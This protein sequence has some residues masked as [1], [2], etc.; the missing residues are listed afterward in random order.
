[1]ARTRPCST[2]TKPFN[3]P[4]RKAPQTNPPLRTVCFLH[5]VITLYH[6]SRRDGNRKICSLFPTNLRTT[7]AEIQDIIVLQRQ[8]FIF[9]PPINGGG[10]E[11]IMKRKKKGRKILAGV[12]AAAIVAGL[13]PSFSLHAQAEEKPSGDGS[14][15]NPYRITSQAE[16]EWISQDPD[17]SYVLSNDIALSGEWKPIDFQGV[18]DGQGHTISGL[19]VPRGNQY[20]EAGLFG[21]V[22]GEIRNLTVQIADGGE[23]A[24]ASAG[25]V[26]GYLHGDSNSVHGDYG[27]EPARMV[28]C[29][30]EGGA[31]LGASSGAYE[32]GGL[33]GYMSDAILE[34]CSSSCTVLDMDGNALITGM[35]LEQDSYILANIYDTESENPNGVTI[36]AEYISLKPEEF[37]DPKPGVWTIAG[38]AIDANLVSMYES[39]GKFDFYAHVPGIYQIEFIIDGTHMAQAVIQACGAEEMEPETVYTIECHAV[40]PTDR[41]MGGEFGGLVGMSNDSRI[42]GS[43]ATGDIPVYTQHEQAGSWSIGGLIGEASHTEIADCFYQGNISLTALDG[44]VSA[45]GLVGASYYGKINKSYMTGS[46][47][48]TGTRGY[49]GGLAGVLS[50]TPAENCFVNSLIFREKIPLSES[51]EKNHTAGFLGIGFNVSL[52]GCYAAAAVK[53]EEETAFG[54]YG[55]DEQD[56]GYN[57]VFTNCYY[58]MDKS[59]L[60]DFWCAGL[61]TEQM[62]TEGGMAGLDYETVWEFRAGENDGY[63]VL[64]GLGG[65]PDQDP[66]TDQPGSVKITIPDS[67]DAEAYLE[68]VAELTT[69]GNEP[70]AQKYFLGGD[71]M[72]FRDLKPGSYTVKIWKNGRILGQW[73]E[74]QVESGKETVVEADGLPEI[75]SVTVKVLTSAEEEVADARIYWYDGETNEYLSYGNTIDGILPGQK[76]AYQVELSSAAQMAG[77]LR[78]DRQEMTA[79][80][81]K[82]QTVSCILERNGTRKI[83]GTVSYEGNALSYIPVT[84]VS[85]NGSQT[86]SA[87]TDEEGYYELFL[88]GGAVTLE[89]AQGRVFYSGEKEIREDTEWDVELQQSDAYTITLDIQ[90]QTAAEDGDGFTYPADG[91]LE[92]IHIYNESTGK[93]LEKFFMEYPEVYLYDAGEVNDGDTLRIEVADSSGE[94]EDARAA[95]TLK[96]GKENTVRVLLAER[97]GVKVLTGEDSPKAD[98]FLYGEDGVLRKKITTA[99]GSG[100]FTGLKSGVYRLVAVE[101][102]QN[103]APAACIDDLEAKGLA[104][105]ELEKASEI[106][107]QDGILSVC[108]DPEI[109]RVG[110]PPEENPYVDT[111][112]CFY[113][114]YPHLSEPQGD[115]SLIAHYGF[116]SESYSDVKESVLEITLPEGAELNS[117]KEVSPGRW[118]SN[119]TWLQDSVELDLDFGTL[120]EEFY[121]EASLIFTAGGTEYRFSLGTIKISPEEE[122]DIDLYA[123][124]R[125]NDREIQV[126]VDT[127][128]FAGLPVEIYDN[129]V[130]IASVGAEQNHGAVL[131]IPVTLLGS[132]DWSQHEIYAAVKTEDGG[133]VQSPY[134]QVSCRSGG[135][136]LDRISVQSGENRGEQYL[137]ESAGFSTVTLYQV[138]GDVT[139]LAKFSD[140]GKDA[141]RNVEFIIKDRSGEIHILNGVYLADREAWAATM[142]V[143]SEANVPVE[144]GVSFVDA[145]ENSQITWEQEAASV[146]QW[147]L[148]ESA[149]NQEY[150]DI[151]M[152]GAVLDD[153]LAAIWDEAMESSGMEVTENGDGNYSMELPEDI[154]TVEITTEDLGNISPEELL[155]EGFQQVPG[156]SEQEAD[157]IYFRVSLEDMKMV[158]IVDYD[159]KERYTAKVDYSENSGL[160]W[161][162]LEP[163][164][165]I[166]GIGVDTADKMIEAWEVH[167][168]KDFTKTKLREYI[169]RQNAKAVSAAEGSA[170]WLKYRQ[171]AKWAQGMIDA[172]DKLAPA[173]DVGGKLWDLFGIA[174]KLWQL[175]EDVNTLVDLMMRLPDVADC[176]QAAYEIN[177]IYDDL[178]R[179]ADS[180]SNQMS[181]LVTNLAL[182][183][184]MAKTKI[185]AI[186]PVIAVNEF[187]DTILTN[188]TQAQLAEI[189]YDLHQLGIVCGDEPDPNLRP[190]VA[191][192]PRM[193][194]KILIDPSG[195]VYEAV[196]SNR[197]E[198]VTATIF[199]KENREDETAIVWDAWNYNQENP[200]TTDQDGRYAWDVPVGWW[201]VKYE[202]DGYLT[203]YSDWLEVPP[204]QT[205]VNIPIVSMA[206]P[207]V[208]TVHFYT[209]SIEVFFTQYLDLES[210][211]DQENSSWKV[212]RNGREIPGTWEA[213]NPE[214]GGD[215]SVSYADGFRFVPES[216][217]MSG[218]YEL[219]VNTARNYAGT[220]MEEPASASG[221]AAARPEKMAVQA[222]PAL[223][224][225]KTADITVQLEPAV[226]N[227]VIEIVNHTP[228]TVTVSGEEVKTDQN[229]VAVFQVS[230]GLPG[231]ARIDL[232]LKDSDLAEQLEF[233]VES[234]TPQAA[235]VEASPDGG[236]LKSGS[237]ISLHTETPGAD[238]YYTL[239][240]SCPCVEDSPS[241]ILYTEPVKLTE[242]GEVTLIAC[243]VKEGYQDSETSRFIYTVTDASDEPGTDEP[244]TDDPDEP[245]T[246]EPGT[247][248]PDEPGTDEP[249]ADNPNDPGTENP[250]EP[251]TDTPDEPAQTGED[252]PMTGQEGQNRNESQQS[253]Q[254]EKKEAEA[255]KSGDPSKTA[256]LWL[257]IFSAAGAAVICGIRRKIR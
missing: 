89:A 100:T 99:A 241:R 185:A 2:E 138:P 114:I 153:E 179:H 182:T 246:D 94:C 152:E 68:C 142:E 88:P 125:T 156:L 63:P 135:V 161:P 242:P 140:S 145:S 81:E 86:A 11:M 158:D 95:V 127:Q 61:S 220:Q 141:V 56:T 16:L 124:S 208:E 159:A 195:Y 50:S 105:W 82:E 204:P 213:L 180:L 240:G 93:Y 207:E 7:P 238:I 77:Y 78:P 64:A 17:A 236:E 232:L 144:V 192:T 256:V 59:G 42:Q 164:G 234:P 150:A 163:A 44:N 57:E 250:D 247:D 43:F 252:E 54:F 132:G 116:L 190:T 30:S 224:N 92:T 162:D 134:R 147:I 122:R 167:Y 233:P 67:V 123:P 200:L 69:A 217:T 12:L 172:L 40:G 39:D 239:D 34:G 51:G 191:K 160:P 227:Q 108:E 235:P 10:Q 117:M 255:V 107:I 49:V 60:E 47:S 203:A 178:Q 237:E 214:A 83:S 20:S 22:E 249:G 165:Q 137:N 48:I 109:F 45:G 205:E 253:G 206:V 52:T 128:G 223:E 19:H 71:S 1:M 251:G 198:D 230:A 8:S 25:A 102:G 211:P 212:V 62:K 175:G 176:P 201:Q 32:C 35:E 28:N 174:Q 196:P 181:I 120:T 38:E 73:D 37:P 194:M 84:A 46:L 58:D 210:L 33:V 218:E 74:I 118:R 79:G 193:K 228:G 209:D 112:E 166:A 131:T 104:G 96:K 72:V 257:L 76:L 146:S 248:D 66:G 143:T 24:G 36:A 188:R 197:V 87:V 27:G 115:L 225:G 121:S 65:N 216:G 98:L 85:E 15:D 101:G 110:Q 90:R 189:D 55:A 53:T 221:T 139:F 4:E 9:V 126:S 170:E 219:T 254:E 14:G 245:G 41:A 3:A 26:A 199:Y 184:I 171:N 231:T 151:S 91:S 169:D 155:A 97:G 177:T 113:I 243:A 168:Q 80:E 70:V 215:A 136:V 21:Y 186:V 244:G 29:H 119:A 133:L 229:G 103:F 148:A 129:G 187:A 111:G 75:C 23:V 149:A 222:V 154:G 18:F 157:D 183:D 6:G 106:Q 5:E 130:C 13:M 173:I 226:A 31:V 202:K